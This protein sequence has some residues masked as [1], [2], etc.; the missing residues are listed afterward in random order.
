MTKANGKIDLENAKD[1][2]FGRMNVEQKLDVIMDALIDISHELNEVRVEG[3]A[4]TEKVDDLVEKV[5]NLD[6]VS[7]SYRINGAYDDD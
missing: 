2:I 3:E 4:L 7:S 5:G 6:L 1:D